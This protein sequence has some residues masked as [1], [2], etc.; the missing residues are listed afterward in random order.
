MC[1]QR[2]PVVCLGILLALG[3]CLWA[4][5]ALAQVQTITPSAPGLLLGVYPS[6]VFDV[7]MSYLT[8]LDAWSR[9]NGG[10]NTS[11]AAT[12][13]LL[14]DP[15]S[16]TDITNAWNAGYV[17]FVNILTHKRADQITSAD[18]VPWALAI[19][20]WSGPGRRV[21]IAPLP[22]MNGCWIPYGTNTDVGGHCGGTWVDNRNAYKAAFRL[23]QDVFTQYGV[24]A[25]AV[26]WVFAPNNVS[27]PPP[28]GSGVPDTDPAHYTFENYYPEDANHPVDVVGYSAFNFGAFQPPFWQD[29]V[30][31]FN[32]PS[33][34][35]PD[36]GNYLTRMRNNW[37]TKPIFITQTGACPQSGHD[38]SPW[39]SQAYAYLADQGVRA[40]LWFNY[41]AAASG[42]C[43]F[44]FY[45]PSNNIFFTSYPQQTGSDTRVNVVPP[46]MLTA[47]QN[48]P[49]FSFYDV[50]GGFAGS[51]N[52]SIWYPYV[53]TIRKAGITSGIG[54]CSAGPV[55]YGPDNLVSRDQLAMFLLKSR[56]GAGYSP[57]TS[58]LTN[59]FGDTN[60]WWDEAWICDLKNKG[61]T[62]GCGGGNYCP[63]AAVPR[64]QL[65]I[66]LLKTR[67]GP[68]YFPNS[69][70]LTGCFAD[71]N[72]WWDEAWICDLKNK[73]ITSGCGGN[74]YCPTSNVTR[75][76][77]SVLLQRMF[78]PV[79]SAL[80]MSW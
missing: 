27:A 36:P 26:R 60:S 76:E 63:T 43:D 25:N 3:C 5:V 20:S 4:P 44:T 18:I 8:G 24:P 59:C 38:K 29:P 72:G 12:F 46:P 79:N 31:V 30:A 78:S 14:E 13:W 52:A 56:Y 34:T 64:D 68:G 58:P 67:F 35:P 21:F 71:T 41:D 10:K 74:N 66:L 77:I 9:Q 69:S 33:P 80:T 61:I 19:A 54:G 17:P 2:R 11:I 28:P 49:G 57:N 53:E 75:G 48:R 7:G 16:T 47:F 62:S 23:F 55:C 39:I 15:A 51:T 73:G 45:D 42:Q 40:V 65:A 50:I 22:E 70:P 37:P 6:G 32:N 1:H